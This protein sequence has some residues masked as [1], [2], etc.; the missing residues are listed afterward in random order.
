LNGLKLQ[1]K[2]CSRYKVPPHSRDAKWFCKFDVDTLDLV[3]GGYLGQGE[4]KQVIVP[5]MAAFDSLS[6]SLDNPGKDSMMFFF[7]Q[8]FSR[9]PPIQL[10]IAF[11][12]FNSIYKSHAGPTDPDAF[13]STSRAIHAAMSPSV[14]DMAGD[15]NEHVMRSFARTCSGC[16]SPICATAGG[17]AAQQAIKSCSQKFLPMLD[18]QWLYFDALDAAPAVDAS[19][20]DAQNCRYDG[21]IALFG[22]GVQ[23]VLGEMKVF[24]VGAGALGCELI[25]NFALMG[26]GCG[27]NGKVV[28]TD[29]DHIEKSNLSRQ[30]LFRSHHI[31]KG[32]SVVAAESA[33]SINTSLR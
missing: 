21:Q 25:K 1:A 5:E 11:A 17:I 22:R 9:Q 15:L 4:I 7:Q 20:F 28:I 26:V 16:V 31:G 14:K 23:D 32:K 10:H 3:I 18:P 29:N 13:V 24:L 2:N 12:A 33:K 27:Q 8:Q 30:F 19:G 6:Q